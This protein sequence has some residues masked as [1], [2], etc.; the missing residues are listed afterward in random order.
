MH[1]EITGPPEVPGG[2][3]PDDAPT[4]LVT[5]FGADRPGVTAAL[6]EQITA[7]EAET[8]YAARVARSE[9]RR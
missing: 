4:L 9:E 5:V 2:A 1:S 8:G 6:F 7:Y 3:L